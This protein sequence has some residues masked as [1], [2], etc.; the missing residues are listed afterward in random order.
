MPTVD[1]G[2]PAT[3]T[4]FDATTQWVFAEEHIRSKSEN[5]PFVGDEMVGKP[6][7][8]YNKSQFV[9]NGE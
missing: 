6:W 8:I 9:A 3:L 4:I 5:T 7:A 2:A 1:E